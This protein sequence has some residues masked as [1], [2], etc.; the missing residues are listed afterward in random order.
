MLSLEQISLQIN[1][2]NLFNI[3][4]SLLPS[5]IMYLKGANGSGKT[6]LL[7]MIAGIQQPSSGK[8]LFYNQEI[9]NL[10]K[11]YCNY[12][13]HNLGL[14]SELKVLDYLKFWSK[15]YNSTETLEAAIHYFDLFDLLD[16]KCYEL[17]KGNKKRVELSKLLCCQSDLWLL[18]EVESNLDDKNSRLLNNLI[19]SKANNNGIVIISSHLEPTIKSAVVLDLGRK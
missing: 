9:C 1:N 18:D 11:P 15:V 17:S 19:V 6:S 14:K 13:G 2:S 16:K 12:I 10:A 3:A 4:F 8:I 7:R 5:C